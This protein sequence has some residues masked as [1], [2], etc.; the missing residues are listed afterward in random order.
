MSSES[1]RASA[2]SDTALFY[3]RE[4]E[5]LLAENFKNCSDLGTFKRMSNSAVT[6]LPTSGCIATNES[7]QMRYFMKFYRNKKGLLWIFL[8]CLWVILM[9]KAWIL[10]KV[11]HLKALISD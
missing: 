4:K 3:V 8:L 11:P 2:N 7:F 1:L 10:L 9:P 5:W 6:P